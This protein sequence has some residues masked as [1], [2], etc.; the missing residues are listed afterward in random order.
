MQRLMTRQLMTYGSDAGRRGAVI[1]PDLAA[2]R[3]TPNEDRSSWTY[4]LQ[5]NMRWEDGQ[6]ITVD[7]VAEGIRALDRARRDAIKVKAAAILR[8][9]ATIRNVDLVR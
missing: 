1:V 7:E 8:A 9:R 5:P 2:G 3:G 4:E 6:S